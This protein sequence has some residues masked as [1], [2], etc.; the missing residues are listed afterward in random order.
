MRALARNKQPLWY[1]LYT[2]KTEV[3]DT[4]SLFTGEYKETYATPVKA[5]MNISP[6]NGRSALEA[7]GI[8]TNYDKVLVTDDMACPIAE[9]T[10]LWIGVE[11]TSVVNNETVQNPYNFVVSRVSKSLNSIVYGVTEVSVSGSPISTK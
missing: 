1:A 7:F 5:R 9:D 8:A 3:Y 2:G 6:A 10:I 4:N 11:P